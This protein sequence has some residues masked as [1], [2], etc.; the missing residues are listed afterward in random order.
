MVK[1]QRS[2]IARDKP[3]KDS[4][5]YEMMKQSNKMKDLNLKYWYVNIFSKKL[6]IPKQKKMN[7]YC[8]KC[9]KITKNNKFGTYIIKINN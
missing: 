1:T 7:F 3:I 4:R 6:S 2:N 5:K 8:A 9:L